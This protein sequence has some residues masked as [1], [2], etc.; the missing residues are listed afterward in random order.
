MTASQNPILRKL[1]YD[2]NDRVVLF[3]ADDIGMCQSTLPAF[4][5][6][7]HA[8]LVT[9]GSAMVPCPWFPAVADWRSEH[10]EVDL[11]VHL[12]L[13]SE[14]ATYRWRP[15]STADRA[16][17]LVDQD[18]YLP[19][20]RETLW[21]EAAPATIASEL[22]A[23]LDQAMQMDLAPTHIDSHMYSALHP[24]F[25]S[26]YVELALEHDLPAMLMWPA[27]E[28]MAPE[29]TAQAAAQLTAHSLPV[30]DYLVVLGTS[31]PAA[32]RLSQARHCLA[33]LPAG[34]TCWLLHPAQ[35]TP[36]LQAIAPDWPYRVADYTLFL[37]PALQRYVQQQG[38]QV[39]N[40]QYLS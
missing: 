19:H 6:L 33:N 2:A 16:T 21:A 28:W 31:V 17:G 8:G 26:R 23:Q 11:G 3:H 22:H 1:G 34:L 5:D 24:R 7:L 4:D 25:L 9:S 37:N 40:Y 36:E 10:P 27:L 12:T 13:T 39:I 18:G 32:E 38:I 15:V 14:W 35:P 20:R 30:F 29:P